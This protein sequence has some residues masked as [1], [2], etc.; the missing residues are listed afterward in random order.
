MEMFQKEPVLKNSSTKVQAFSL[1]AIILVSLLFSML[2][3]IVIALPFW[4]G[5]IVGL[6]EGTSRTLSNPSYISF[7]KY[8]QAFNQFGLFIIPS[9]FF[10]FLL[11]RKVFDYLRLNAGFTPVHSRRSTAMSRKWTRSGRA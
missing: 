4:G 2:F 3:S 10:S 11:H 9:I 6:A 7:L 1:L 8:S 5:E